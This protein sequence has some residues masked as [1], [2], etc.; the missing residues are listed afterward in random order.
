MSASPSLI[1]DEMMPL[2][3]AEEEIFSRRMRLL[4]KMD[5]RGID[6]YV[7]SSPAN[8]YYIS[9]FFH[10]TPGGIFCL[11]LKRDGSAVWIGRRTE[12]SNVTVFANY[13]WTGEGIAI[14]DEEDPQEGLGKAIAS[15]AEPGSTICL[16]LSGRY[17]ISYSAFEVLK[18]ELRGHALVDSAGMVESLRAIKSDTE[19]A[20][21]R[22]AGQIS[23]DAIRAAVGSVTPGSTDS[24]LAGKLIAEAVRGGS[25]YMSLGPYVTAGPRSF[26]AHSSWGN[27]PLREGEIINTEIAA[28]VARY[29][30]PVFRVSV[31]GKPSDDIRRFHEAS[32]AG[33]QAGLDKIKPGMKS[34][35]A[36]AVV[37]QAIDEKGY[38]EYFVVRAAYGVGINY[39]PSWDEEYV[40]SIRP[41]D[42]R[43]LKAGM[44][45]HLVPA[46]YKR[47]LGCVCC[48]MTIHITESGVES[49]TPIPA[50]LIQIG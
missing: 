49:L 17:P 10:G 28:V 13:G 22:R 46:L 43:T 26:L 40:M 14:G 19:L 33:L 50:E 35:E 3:F 12:M 8:Y 27:V 9:G 15:L 16:E 48:S 23:S 38:G 45:F 41:R 34:L 1:R 29:S 11:A 6:L 7:I 37:R 21:M 20:Y 36:D 4:E 25:E 44:C 31:L 39:P 5:R 18:C 2:Y 24:E 42:E 32:V 47:D 30:A